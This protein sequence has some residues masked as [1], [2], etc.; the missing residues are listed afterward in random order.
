MPGLSH[1]DVQKLLTNPCEEVRVETLEKIA[2]G[3]NDTDFTDNQKKIAQD[4]FRSLALDAAV[5]V[6]K[7]L[8]DHLKEN[9]DLPRDIA[10]QLASDVD[11]VALPMIECTDVLNE[12]DLIQIIQSEGVE[13]QKAIARRPHIS[14][15]VSN[16]L[17]ETK[18]KEVVKEVVENKT[19][20]ISENSFQKIIEYY[21]DDE[22]IHKPL[23]NRDQLPLTVSE[24]LISHVSDSLKQHL[25]KKHNISKDII[26]NIIL[27]TQE[28]A[29]INLANCTNQQ[30][31]QILVKHLISEKRLTPTL[32]LRALCMGYIQF[33]ET[34]LAFKASI[35]LDNAR[36]LVRDEGSKG[37]MELCKKAMIPPK[38]F[39][40]FKTA[41]NTV[42]A[43]IEEGI[44]E[45]FSEVVIER[46]LTQV[47]NESDFG[48]ENIDYL[49]D[50]ISHEAA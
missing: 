15:K 33:F 26:D 49:I 47:N 35:S 38:Y 44:E 4:I 5:R 17:I 11:E 29:I 22:D 16:E 42:Q 48:V 39:P 25:V 28:R 45:N 12:E 40:F 8:S 46:V 14:E 10:F 43:T 3:Y 21:P 2:G 19:A 9:S 41:V 31:V 6:R 34:C 20:N 1:S 7:A 50:K 23:V 30:E 32:L 13:K 24:K 37:L 27:N 18:N 36:T